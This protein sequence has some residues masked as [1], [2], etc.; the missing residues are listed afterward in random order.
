MGRNQPRGRQ[1]AEESINHVIPQFTFNLRQLV[2]ARRITIYF[3]MRKYDK[4]EP[5]KNFYF[6]LSLFVLLL[7][8][9]SVLFSLF[10]CPA[11]SLFLS[12][13]VLNFFL[14]FH[15]FVH[16]YFYYVFL[17]CRLPLLSFC[18]LLQLSLQIF[19]IFSHISCGG[20]QTLVNSR[21]HPFQLL[22]FLCSLLIS[23][24]PYPH[25]SHRP[26][27]FFVPPTL[28]RAQLSST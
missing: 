17:F 18:L 23:P 20:Q 4:A 27:S 11:F 7:D 15:S 16:L 1:P 9:L 8:F 21:F 6:I 10:Q 3:R 28:R 24:T 14:N 19:F 26:N 22:S 12:T 2:S 25:Q 13:Y 5:S